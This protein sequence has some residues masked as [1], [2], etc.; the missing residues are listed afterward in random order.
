MPSTVHV[1]PRKQLG[2]ILGYLYLI[3]ASLT[4]TT[5]NNDNGAVD[6]TTLLFQNLLDVDALISPSDAIKKNESNQHLKRI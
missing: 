5:K 1:M 4:N 6:S 3:A 2:Y